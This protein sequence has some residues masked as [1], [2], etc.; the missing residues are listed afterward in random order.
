MIALEFRIDIRAKSNTVNKVEF[1]LTFKHLQRQEL[2]DGKN[3]SNAA[4]WC[5][6][7]G[8]SGGGGSGPELL[9]GGGQGGAREVRRAYAATPRYAAGS[10]G[11]FRDGDV[12]VSARGL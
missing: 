1:V 10:A 2:E 9:A 3:G 12:P 5:E 4:R 7:R 8:L 6:A 11:V